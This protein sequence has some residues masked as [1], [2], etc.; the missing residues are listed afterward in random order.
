MRKAFIFFQLLVF[1]LVA[2]NGSA[3]VNCSDQDLLRMKGGWKKRSDA[4]MRMFRGDTKMYTYLSDISHIFQSTFPVMN[5]MEAGWYQSMGDPIF[6]GAPVSYCFNSLYLA[7]YCNTNLHKMMLSDETGT[8]AYVFVN[9]PGWL[10]SEQYDRLAIKVNNV[11]VYALPARKGTWKGHDLYQPSAHGAS[12]KCILLTRGNQ[13]PWVPVTQ[14]QYLRS[15]R[16][17]VEEQKKGSGPVASSGLTPAM[18][19]ADKKEIEKIQNSNILKPETKQ[20][21][22]DAIKKREAMY[23]NPGNTANGAASG[24]AVRKR[25][26]LYDARLL[27]I[28]N[29]LSHTSKE[30]LDHPAV[31]APKAMDSFEGSFSSEELGGRVLVSINPGYFNKGLSGAV[32]QLMVLYW[33]WDANPA[34][35]NFKK[36]FEEEFP[37]E[38][39]QAMLDTPPGK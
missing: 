24:T 17:R 5:G 29:Y 19:E 11:P 14:E 13:L 20:A 26:E 2:G 18:E 21:M 39:L 37:V 1:L 30:Q 15:L 28:D 10:V 22:M 34:A 25:D 12:G 9:S 35:Q 23:Q 32:P 31:V 38:K 6:Q 3:Q 4:N 27:S 16:A 33:R 36:Q 7:W 8:W